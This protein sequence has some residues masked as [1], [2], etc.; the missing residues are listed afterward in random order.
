VQHGIDNG[1]F[2]S[3]VKRIKKLTLEC[4]VSLAAN[5]TVIELYKMLFG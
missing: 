2:E 4:A 5:S 3:V 1:V